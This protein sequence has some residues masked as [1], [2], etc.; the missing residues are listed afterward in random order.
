VKELTK[1]VPTDA[2]HRLPEQRAQW[3]MAQLIDWHWREGKPPL[4]IL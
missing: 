1:D 3:L 2:D 4:G